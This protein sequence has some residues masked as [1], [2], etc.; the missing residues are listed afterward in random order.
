MNTLLSVLAGVVCGFLSGLGVGGGS[1]LMAYMT[2][3]CD[4]EQRTAQGINLLYYLPAAVCALIFHIRNGAV[5]WRAVIFCGLAGI[6][7]AI[8]GSLL[9][10]A[11]ESELLQKLF[12]GFLILVGVVECVKGFRQKS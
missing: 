1:L 3:I 11:V 6:C 10:G 7:G 2:V 12:G 4:M 5:V 9:S 8:A